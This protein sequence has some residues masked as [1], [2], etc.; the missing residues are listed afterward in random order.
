MCAC[1]CKTVSLRVCGE[2]LSIDLLMLGAVLPAPC[3]NRSVLRCSR[4]VCVWDT[5]SDR[6]RLYMEGESYAGS[7]TKCAK[8]LE[9]VSLHMFIC[10]RVCVCVCVCI[11][12]CVCVCLSFE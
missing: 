1:V 12:V 10:A 4:R 8:V 2:R 3:R 5:E 6:E 7:S 11:C 9:I